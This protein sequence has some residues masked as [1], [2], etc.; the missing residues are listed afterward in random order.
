[1][2]KTILVG[3]MAIALVLSFLV[4]YAYAGTIFT[5]VSNSAALQLN[6]K[7]GVGAMNGLNDGVSHFATNGTDKL[8]CAVSG[9]I[10]VL[11]PSTLVYIESI[12]PIKGKVCAMEYKNDS[13]YVLVAA[14][15]EE[16]SKNLVLVISGLQIV[17]EIEV[18]ANPSDMAVS[19]DGSV[20]YVARAAASRIDT[21]DTAQGRTFNSIFCGEGSTP[22]SIV[23]NAN[24]TKLYAADSVKSEVIVAEA[25]D[26]NKAYIPE[27]N[28]IIKRIAAGKNCQ[29]VTIDGSNVLA[30]DRSEETKAVYVINSS[31][32]VIA[33]TITF[34]TAPYKVAAN[35]DGSYSV[36][37]TNVGD[38][39]YKLENYAIAAE[40][41]LHS[42]VSLLV[43]SETFSMPNVIYS[44]GTAI[45]GSKTVS[46]TSSG[47]GLVALAGTQGTTPTNVV[48]TVIKPNG[49]E[50]W[51]AVRDIWYEAINQDGY[52]LPPSYPTYIKCVVNTPGGDVE[53]PL[54]TGSVSCSGWFTWDTAALGLDSDKCKIKVIVVVNT[55]QYS[56]LSDAY[57]TVDNT[58]PTVNITDPPETDFLNAST[59]VTVKATAS[60]ALCGVKDPLKIKVNGTLAGTASYD[61][62][63]G[64]YIG[65]VTISND[66]VGRLN[67]IEVIA[68]DNADDGGGNGNEGSDAISALVGWI[69]HID[70]P[71]SVPYEINSLRLSSGAATSQIILDVMKQGAPGSPTQP[72]T[73]DEIFSTGWNFNT[74]AHKLDPSWLNELDAYGMDGALDDPTIDPW[75]ATSPYNFAV[76]TYSAGD[77]NSYLRDIAC[78]LGYPIPNPAVAK[79]IPAAVPKYGFTLQ[80]IWWVAVTGVA[81]DANP[82]PTPAGRIIY[83]M[84]IT[85]PE[86]G[87]NNIGADTYVVASSLGAL[88]QP[89]PVDYVSVVEPP[90][91][92]TG[93]IDLA[94]PSVN[95]STSALVEIAEC[96]NSNPDSLEKHMVDSALVVDMDEARPLVRYRVEGD[97]LNLFKPTEAT[98][99]PTLCWKEIISPMLLTDE[100]FKKA[101]DGALAR[102]F[103][104][105]KRLDIDEEYLLIPFDKFTEGKF[106]SY[107]ALIVDKET[108]AFKEGS[109]VKEPTRYVQ[110]SKQ[111]AIEKVIELHPEAVTKNIDARLVW[112][113]GANMTSSPFYPYWEVTAGEN[114]YYVIKK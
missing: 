44:E 82:Y 102:D 111:E 9:K 29:Q 35:P 93:T 57:F 23:L 78:W 41:S 84:W 36:V 114:K 31:S 11:N 67:T 55:T 68:S 73:Q 47:D 14:S 48:V 20:A 94:P 28:F 50:K 25:P 7:L 62:G 2:K 54:H 85:D 71:H 96:F 26:K 34:P 15:S 81:A 110:L 90:E 4:S 16:V 43:T 21:V 8:Y 38:K 69:T 12:G 63:Q 75:G 58:P 51:R 13:L 61:I 27:Y 17:K 76:R 99:S 59:S 104:Y 64:K 86:Q 97:L 95:S 5:G 103:L 89:A 113:P 91:W 112:S 22:S 49:S 109:W 88:L 10:V 45:E 19:S 65:T 24:G 32:D 60:D 107:A 70:L 87:V 100:N 74:A 106:L 52:P 105:V 108:G 30:V 39:I 80:P 77:F 3:G 98:N 40:K 66:P 83:G 18:G 42:P 37:I 72:K 56:D 46:V 33:N 92:A 53:Y 101:I 79:H 1:M 6:D